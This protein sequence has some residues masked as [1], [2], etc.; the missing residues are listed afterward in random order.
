MKAIELRKKTDS[1]LT[2]F[3]DETR[4]KLHEI[5][6]KAAS[7]QIKDATPLRVAKRDI[8]RVLTILRERRNN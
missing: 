7:G 8:A 2:K 4:C 3:L 5:S 1:E 6:F